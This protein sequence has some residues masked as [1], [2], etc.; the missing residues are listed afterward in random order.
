[1][2]SLIVK[3]KY[4]F[5]SEG[6]KLDYPEL[7][8]LF[9]VLGI[10]SFKDISRL[11]KAKKNFDLYRP[12]LMIF[13]SGSLELL[14]GCRNHCKF[15]LTPH[16]KGDKVQV[17]LEKDLS[18]VLNLFQPISIIT[19]KAAVFT[20]SRTITLKIQTSATHPSKNCQPS[21]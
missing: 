9:K 16:R 10:N 6:F 15:L 13:S 17:Q 11:R 18:T 7:N 14:K 4:L 21:G 12:I 1:M 5:K 8:R 3:H 20:A 2:T 19:L